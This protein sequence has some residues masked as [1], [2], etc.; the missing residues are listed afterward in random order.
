MNDEIVEYI[1]KINLQ[2]NNT[3]VTLIDDN[4]ICTYREAAD[5][6]YI[7]TDVYEYVLNKDEYSYCLIGQAFYFPPSYLLP[8]KIENIYQMFEKE[9]FAN[10][11]GISAIL[12]FSL[13]DETF[14]RRSNMCHLDNYKPIFDIYFLESLADSI[15]YL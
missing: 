4:L 8:I 2:H 1:K 7:Y 5:M 14:L 9:L 13:V 12:E 15:S 11:K 10:D 6:C 3:M